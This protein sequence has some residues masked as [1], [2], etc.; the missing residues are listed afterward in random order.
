MKKIPTESSSNFDEHILNTNKD[1]ILD[2]HNSTTEK[3]TTLDFTTISSI[4][5]GKTNFLSSLLKNKFQNSSFISFLIFTTFSV[6]SSNWLNLFNNDNEDDKLMSR[7]NITFLLIIFFGAIF[8]FFI[9]SNLFG[10]LR[11]TKTKYNSISSMIE[12]QLGN[13]CAI[14]LQSGI[15]LWIG[16]NIVLSVLTC[17]IFIYF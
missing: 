3:E 15:F 12:N 17:N 10:L 4:S 7:D 2:F 13:L 6:N 8:S 9:T 5:Q 11:R 16:F 1:N 14:L